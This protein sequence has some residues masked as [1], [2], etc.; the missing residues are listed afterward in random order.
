MGSAILFPCF[1]NR[2]VI[3]WHWL[4]QKTDGSSIKHNEGSRCWASPPQLDGSCSQ[5]QEP[6]VFKWVHLGTPAPEIW[7]PNKFRF[8]PTRSYSQAPE[9]RS[10]SYTLSVT[11]I[12]L[13]GSQVILSLT[14]EYLNLLVTINTPSSLLLLNYQVFPLTDEV[15]L[16]SIII[17]QVLMNHFYTQGSKSLSHAAEGKMVS[18]QR[19]D[20]LPRIGKNKMDNEL[21]IMINMFVG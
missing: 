18:H 6:T 9:R 1:S 2:L 3:C 11:G 21:Y 15:L 13:G 14:L 12:T 19:P 16:L 7:S 17:Q 5:V 4:W 10:R 20:T 8:Q